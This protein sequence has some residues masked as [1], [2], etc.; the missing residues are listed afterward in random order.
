MQTYRDAYLDYLRVEKGLAKNSVLAYAQDLD[1]YFNSL[2]QKKITHPDKIT[3]PDITDF[4]FGLRQNMSVTSI[5][6]ILSTIRGFHSFLV[7]EKIVS[8]NPVDLIDAPKLDKKIP[9]FLNEDEVARLLKESRDRTPQG[10]RDR[11]IVE[12]LYACGLRVSE[13]ASLSLESLFLES[14]FLKCKGKGSKERIVPI[15]KDALS[16]LEKYLL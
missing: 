13:L 8:S 9:E 12:L 5:A 4:L 11:A 10:M 16:Y 6:R 15:G 3:R 1:K 14:G 7:R 2:E